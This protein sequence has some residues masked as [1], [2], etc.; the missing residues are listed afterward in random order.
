MGCTVRRRSPGRVQS[1][2]GFMA[3]NV[4]LEADEARQALC[5]GNLLR[6]KRCQGGGRRRRIRWGPHLALSFNWQG[7]QGAP[8]RHSDEHEEMP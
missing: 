4:T 3:R 8:A 6:L 2:L 5:L 1:G 7:G